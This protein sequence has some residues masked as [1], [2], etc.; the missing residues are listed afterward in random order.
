MTLVASQVRVAGTGE[1]FVAAVGEAA[2]ADATV[3]LGAAWKGL[4]YTQP[5]GATI[6]R[7][8][9]REPIEAWQS[10]TPLRYIYNGAE[11]TIAAAMLQSN[12]QIAGLWFGG[13]DFAETAPGSGEYKADMPTV[14]EGIERAILL[15]FVDDTVTSRIYIP[16]AELRET[17]D[18]QISRT[19]P[20]A[21]QMTWGALAPDSGTV[22]ATWLT[23]DPNFA[24]PA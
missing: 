16:R 7:A 1:L 17:G 10:V 6:G 8:L 23:N 20:A 24:P 4:G 13:G 15:E 19:A 14:P 3:A 18:V 5:E 21:F 12:S 22:L 9:D 2:P 11:L